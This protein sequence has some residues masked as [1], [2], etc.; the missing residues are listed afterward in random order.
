MGLTPSITTSD[1]SGT[2][3]LNRGATLHGSNLRGIDGCYLRESGFAMSV[4]E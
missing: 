4:N 1:T 2:G 3:I